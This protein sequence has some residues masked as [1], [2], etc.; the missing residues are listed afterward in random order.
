MYDTS[1]EYLRH[2]LLK[3]WSED[4]IIKTSEVSCGTEKKE[5]WKCS[6]SFHRP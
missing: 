3:E 1:I 5:W 4:N 2:D 6:N